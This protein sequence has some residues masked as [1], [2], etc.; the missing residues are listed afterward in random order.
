MRERGEILP[1]KFPPVVAPVLL[2]SLV[3]SKLILPSHLKHLRRQRDT[4]LFAR[5]QTRIANGLERFVERVYQPSLSWAVRHR[6]TVLAVFSAMALVMA[7]YCVG[8][9]MG[10]VSFPSVDRQRITA[11]LDL[12]DNTP[13]ETTAQYMDRIASALEQVKSEFVDP[14]SG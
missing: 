2:F 12:P 10:F 5:F 3:E 13:L 1:S 9:R 8:G 14:G 4:N 6:M 11:I 7:G